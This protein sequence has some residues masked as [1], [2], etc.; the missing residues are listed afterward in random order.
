MGKKK[1]GKGKYRFLW[2]GLGLIVSGIFMC[3]NMQAATIGTT[4]NG[5]GFY[6]INSGV[7]QG[8][9]IEFFRAFASTQ[10]ALRFN[11]D[12]SSTVGNGNVDIS[13]IFDERS[14]AITV[15]PYT[16]VGTITIYGS[17]GTSAT[18]GSSMWQPIYSLPINGTATYVFSGKSN[19]LQK[20]TWNAA[21]TIPDA[22]TT[23]TANVGIP[24]CHQ[25]CIGV[26]GTYTANIGGTFVNYKR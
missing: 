11:T 13:D 15:N 20:T 16:N 9:E 14:L 18:N 22:V 24:Y 3:S 23:I 7:V 5:V 17:F 21:G 19:T 25:L 26:S 12:G 1:R 8:R 6:P 4:T 2:F 10:S